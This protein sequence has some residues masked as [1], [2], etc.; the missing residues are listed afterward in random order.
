MK[1]LI[2]RAARD[3]F[4]ARHV[5]VLTGAGISTESGIPDFRSPGGLWEKYDP[6]E[7][8]YDRFL[9]DPKRIWE[10]SLEMKK[11]GDLDMAQAKPNPAHLALAELERMGHIKCVITQN[12]DNLHQKAGSMDVI[13]FHGNMLWAKC[14]KCDIRYPLEEVE[15]KLDKHE[16]PPRCEKCSGILKPDA[17][18]FGESIPSASLY[19]SISEAKMADV[20]IVAG[21]SAVVY[22]AAELPF[23]AKRGGGF[24]STSVTEPSPNVGAIII[25]VNDEPTQLTGRVSDYLLQGKVGTVL[26]AIVEAI[27]ELKGSMAH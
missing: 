24:F 13:E 2:H 16:L 19:R 22:P 11:N 9:A 21:T 26:P 3:I 14:I 12:V 6:M 25:E 7:F 8:L 23:V 1:E 27:V 17:V 10:M 18:F 4:N 20:M 5:V 15:K